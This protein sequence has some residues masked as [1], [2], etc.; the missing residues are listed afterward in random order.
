MAVIAKIW[1]GHSRFRMELGTRGLSSVWQA[2]EGVKGPVEREVFVILPGSCGPWPRL[3]PDSW[4]AALATADANAALRDK[5]GLPVVVRL[6]LGQ[7]LAGFAD[8]S[9]LTVSVSGGGSRCDREADL[10]RKSR[11]QDFSPLPDLAPNASSRHFIQVC[12]AGMQ[13][14]W[15]H[16]PGV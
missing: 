1:N 8:V 14:M 7:K 4:H 16:A 15:Y 2:A 11:S 13:V 5:E 9:S 12:R 3:E 10:E 6:C